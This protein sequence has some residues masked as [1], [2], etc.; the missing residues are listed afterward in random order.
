VPPIAELTRIE[1]VHLAR[2][3]AHGVFTTGIL[4]EVSETVT[5][6]QYL[7]DQVDAS[8]N[9]VMSW[10]DEALLLNLAGLRP[11]DHHLFIQA[12]LDGIR[13]ILALDLPMFREALS[14]AATELGREPPPDL[15]IEGWWDQARTLDTLPTPERPITD[16]PPETGRA[17]LVGLGAVILGILAGM[18][19]AA[20]ASYSL[21]FG[22]IDVSTAVVIAPGVFLVC[23]LV[24]GLIGGG[25][26]SL[27][28]FALVSSLLVVVA[29]PELSTSVTGGAVVVGGVSAGVVGYLA[30][31]LGG[32]LAGV[33][34]G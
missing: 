12:G 26:A 18:A 31:R 23:G 24:L 20:A 17:A 21:G 16:P 7:A 11:E 33:R 9:D 2:L 4:L 15:T 19:V 32:R 3:E 6:R 10:R 22:P 28:S 1:P 29:A 14:T 27:A 25:L 34:V 13:S 5:R 8:I 30:G